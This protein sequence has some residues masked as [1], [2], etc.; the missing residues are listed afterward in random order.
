[1]RTVTLVLIL[2]G[3]AACPT[4]DPAAINEQPMYGNAPKNAAMIEADERFIA[5]V[6]QEGYTREVGSGYSIESGWHSFN[7]GDYST[8][9]KRFNQAWLLDPENGD[10]YY[11]FALITAVRDGDPIEIEEFFH[12]AFKKDDVS[13]AAYV[14]YGRFLWTRERYDE[15]LERLHIAL[16]L[17]PKAFNARAHISFVHYKLG[18]FADACEWG[19]RAKENGDELEDG[20]LADMCSR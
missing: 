4:S 15:S 3:L 6:L 5:S 10:A 9:I 13:V 11:G 19:K 20:Y 12:M 7:K 16:Q 14:D 17:E 1:M 18:N 8:A 2:L